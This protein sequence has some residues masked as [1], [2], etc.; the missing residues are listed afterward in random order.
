[1]KDNELMELIKWAVKE[2]ETIPAELQDVLLGI[3]LIRF[4]RAIKEQ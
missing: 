4:R 1:M 2:I 3:L